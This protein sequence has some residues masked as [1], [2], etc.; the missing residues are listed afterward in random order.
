[1]NVFVFRAGHPNAWRNVGIISLAFFA[2]NSYQKAE[3]EGLRDV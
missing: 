1:M 3:N 2:E